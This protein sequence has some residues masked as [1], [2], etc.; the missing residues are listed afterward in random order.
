MDRLK[1]IALVVA[2]LFAIGAGVFGVNYEVTDVDEVMCG[3]QV[4]RPGH[5]CADNSSDAHFGAGRGYE[6]MRRDQ[7]ANKNSFYNVVGIAAVVAG[8]VMIGIGG[9]RLRPRASTAGGANHPPAQP[10]WNPP[11]APGPGSP[12]NAAGSGQGERG[13]DALVRVVLDFVCEGIAGVVVRSQGENVVRPSGAGL[14]HG[15]A[16]PPGLRAVDSR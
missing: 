3:E 13:R 11:P 10:P 5:R 2:G 4:M 6:A 9:Y 15:D 12:P 1:A 16:R 7:I 14:S 8:L